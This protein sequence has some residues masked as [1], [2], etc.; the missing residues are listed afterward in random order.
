MSI[1]HFQPIFSSAIIKARLIGIRDHYNFT[2]MF[3][4]IKNLVITLFDR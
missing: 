1:Y 3:K 4:R 2:I